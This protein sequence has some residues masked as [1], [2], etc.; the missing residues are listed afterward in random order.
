M[1]EVKY[2]FIDGNY[3]RQAHA[4]MMKKVFGVESNHLNVMSLIGEARSFRTY[5]YD[6]FDEVRNPTESEEAFAGRVS[7]QEKELS[8]IG[9]LSGVHLQLGSVTG[10]GKKKRR[11]K[12]VDVLLAVDMLTHAHNDNMT[13]AILVTGDLDFRPVVEAVVWQGVFVQIW[14]EQSTA[15]KELLRAADDSRLLHFNTLYAWSTTEFTNTHK[16]PEYGQGD[17]FAGE[18]PIVSE[19]IHPKVGR[20]A[21][22][23]GWGKVGFILR[24]EWNE[25]KQWLKHPSVSVLREYFSVLYG[26]VKWK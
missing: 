26:E 23:E 14:Y 20:I 3:I 7:A 16:P 11:Q 25:T 18:T 13:H 8:P 9:D 2:L 10:F 4:G 12:E 17:G 1:D 6:S 24:F 15:S 5:Y 22:H 21:I 19:G